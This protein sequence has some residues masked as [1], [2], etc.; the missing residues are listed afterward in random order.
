MGD[1]GGE[2]AGVWRSGRN[3]RILLGTCLTME[4]LMRLGRVCAGS[5]RFFH[6]R[7]HFRLRKLGG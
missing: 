4:A 5:L 6:A 3:C 1:I 7:V 2:V